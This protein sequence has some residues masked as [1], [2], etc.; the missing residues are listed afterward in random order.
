L[1]AFKSLF[2]LI[3]VPGLLIGYFPYAISMNDTELLALG[4]FR[5]LALPLL[6]VGW[7]VMLWC[8]W[9]FLV[10]GRGTPAP[11]DPPRE[12]V[13]AG[14]YCFVRNPMYAAGL[15]A[16]L[17]WILWSPSF[18]LIA[19]PFLFFVAAHLFVTGYE[20]PTLKKKFGAAYEEYCKQVPR[21]IPK[22]K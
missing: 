19:A 8:F 22:F 13:V 10:N 5:Y 2:F 4:A 20:E 11:F 15:I 6:A 16:L 17:G 7:T 12:L 1:T 9:N 21:W 3:L 14:P 18:P